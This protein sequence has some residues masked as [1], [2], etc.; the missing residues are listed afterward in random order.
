MTRTELN[1]AFTSGTNVDNQLAAIN[2]AREFSEV[3]YDQNN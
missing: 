1:S 3:G 2:L